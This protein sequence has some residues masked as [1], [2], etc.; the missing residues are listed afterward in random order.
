MSDYCSKFIKKPIKI[1]AFLSFPGLLARLIKEKIIVAA[2]VRK[3]T[4]IAREI[5]GEIKPK[6]PMLASIFISSSPTA[7]IL[8]R[9][10]TP[11]K[12]NIAQTI[13]IIFSNFILKNYFL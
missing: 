7:I 1:K 4:N 13:F 5:S 6:S 11:K 9:K 2:T 10:I 8:K 3:K 12:P